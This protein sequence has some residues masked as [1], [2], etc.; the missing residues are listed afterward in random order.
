MASMS[1]C[2]VTVGN[3]VLCDCSSQV[4]TRQRVGLQPFTNALAVGVS[5]RFCNKCLCG[6]A[7]L[8]D[9]AKQQQVVFRG[10]FPIGYDQSTYFSKVEVK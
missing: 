5:S 2:E 4:N 8:N 3:W 7:P 1:V 10:L 6:R 9:E